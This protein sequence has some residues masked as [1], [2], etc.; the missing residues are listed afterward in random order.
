MQ[1]MLQHFGEEE[2]KQSL[3]NLA[4]VWVTLARNKVISKIPLKK[5]AAEQEVNFSKLDSSLKAVEDKQSNLQ[6]IVEEFGGSQEST[7][8]NFN[9]N[10]QKTF[11]RLP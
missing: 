2:L 10:M 11:S 7:F 5:V 6:Q 9:S 1:T 4:N 3:D 8:Q